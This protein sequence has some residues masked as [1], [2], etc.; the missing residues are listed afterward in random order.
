MNSNIIRTRVHHKLQLRV[1]SL[2]ETKVWNFI[3]FDWH[4]HV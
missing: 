2:E 4:P 3:D 1:E